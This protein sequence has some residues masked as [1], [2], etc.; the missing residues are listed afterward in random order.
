MNELSPNKHSFPSILIR[1]YI[2]CVSYVPSSLPLW[3]V[4]I[5]LYLLFFD[6]TSEAQPTQ[7]LA[8]PHTLKPPVDLTIAC[9]WL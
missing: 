3:A 4:N 5:S 1:Y 2:V 9:A 8:R 7:F 6:A